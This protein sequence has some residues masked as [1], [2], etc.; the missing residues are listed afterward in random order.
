MVLFAVKSK[1]EKTLLV[2]GVEEYESRRGDAIFLLAAAGT[3][4]SANAVPLEF[5]FKMGS[6]YAGFEEGAC[7][8]TPARMWTLRSFAFDC[9]ARRCLGLV[10]TCK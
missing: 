1:L 6:G 9:W 2:L 5:M 8:G 4:F 10:C 3:R 7:L